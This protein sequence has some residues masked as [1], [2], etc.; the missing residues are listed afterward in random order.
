MNSTIVTT[1]KAK[2]GTIDHLVTLTL[3][4]L[5]PSAMAFTPGAVTGGNPLS[6]R[7]VIN[8]LAGPAGRTIS[9]YDNSHYSTVPASVTVPPGGSQVIFGIGT[10]PVLTSQIVTLTAVVSAG[11][12][13]ATFQIDP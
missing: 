12:K 3:I 11:S 9:I 1:L 8:G 10:L 5:V 6:C 2:M 4:P 13:S 7:L